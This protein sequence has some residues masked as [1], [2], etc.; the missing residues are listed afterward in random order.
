MPC[1]SHNFRLKG[2]LNQVTLPIMLRSLSGNILEGFSDS[3]FFH[4]EMNSDYM[5]L[6]FAIS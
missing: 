5:S 2:S 6:S 1:S 3:S 4:R